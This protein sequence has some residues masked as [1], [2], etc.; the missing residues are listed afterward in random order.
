MKSNST[1]IAN[2]KPA[3]AKNKLRIVLAI[4]T[5][6][7]IIV[8]LVH[9]IVIQK[10]EQDINRMKQEVAQSN[11]SD[12][13]LVQIRNE[14]FQLIKPVRLIE[15]EESDQLSELKNQISLLID[16]EKQAGRI[17]SASVYFRK[18]IDGRWLGINTEEKYRPGSINKIPLMIYFLKLSEST[19]GLL[20]KKLLY[21]KYM[22]TLKNE[23]YQ[24]ST[25][26]M[27]S[28][29]TIRDLL[30]RMI[31]E[32]DNNATNLLLLH[33]DKPE[34][35][36]KIFS[37]LKM[38]VPQPGSY[39]FTLTASDCSKFLRILYSSTFLSDKNSEFAL[40]LLSKSS[41]KQGLVKS[42]P[43][44]LT[45]A[46]K[47]GESGIIEMPEFSETGIIYNGDLTYLLTV[48]TKGTNSKLQADAISEISKLVYEKVIL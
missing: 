46:H 36:Q 22:P 21:D 35:Y 5:V 13:K 28:T 32:S 41:F 27:G 11:H 20:E 25:M 29:Y 7:L 6:A 30:K 34:L 42:L 26:Q 12:Q 8:I 45:I 4:E 47:F 37:E 38:P 2:A 39:D 43:S 24:S 23:T 44:N 15:N 3:N 10:N 14:E 9:F 17:L 40:D 16:K 33:M 31:V 48:M 18:M 19:P 1:E